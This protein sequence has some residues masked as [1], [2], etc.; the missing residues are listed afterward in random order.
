MIFGSSKMKGHQQTSNHSD[1]SDGYHIRGGTVVLP[2]F[3]NGDTWCLGLKYVRPFSGLN[4]HL[5]T[6]CAKKATKAG[7][8]VGPAF[9]S[10]KG[11]FWMHSSMFKGQ[12]MILWDVLAY[13]FWWWY[14]FHVRSC[15]DSV[16]RSLLGIKKI[17]KN[18]SSGVGNCPVVT[19]TPKLN[20]FNTYPPSIL[21]WAHV[22]GHGPS[23]WF[24]QANTSLSIV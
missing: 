23:M 22:M 6:G 1:P 16:A 14:G 8:W 17:S 10:G 15:Q 5:V 7:P 24:V 4:I 12:V 18:S 11:T 13:K 20:N 19:D 9:G 2:L 3:Q 21:K